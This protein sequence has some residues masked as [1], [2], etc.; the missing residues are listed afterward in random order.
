MKIDMWYGH[1][2]EK[3]KFGADAFFTPGNGYSGNIYDE[4]GKAIGDYRTQN[5]VEIEKNFLIKWND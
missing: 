4:N 2:F 1:K 5:S 3:K